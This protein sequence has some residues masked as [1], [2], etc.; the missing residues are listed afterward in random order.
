MNNKET[1][2]EHLPE[3][4]KT[5]DI[6]KSF[7][8]YCLYLTEENQKVNLI[9][10]KMDTS[11][12][13]TVHFLDSISPAEY[14]DFN[15]KIVLD[16]G[17]GG[18]LPGI[19]LKIL[20]PGMKLFLLDSKLKKINILKNMVK[21]LDLKDCSTIWS[22]FEDMSNSQWSHKFDYII[23]RSVK[24]LPEFLTVFKSIINKKGKLILYKSR[25]LE[26]VEIFQKKEI[27]ELNIPDLGV[28]K[29]IIVSFDNN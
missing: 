15:D 4:F 13:W 22:R 7:D 19:P 5:T 23:C 21:K 29:L 3:K 16:F 6:L 1:F 27:I 25:N 24:M 11:E 28:R 9:S 18:G 10:R 2:I 17:T 14:F 8:N 26:D 20:Y 12:F